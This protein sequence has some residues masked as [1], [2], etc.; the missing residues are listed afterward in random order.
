VRSDGASRYCLDLLAEADE[1]LWLSCHYAGAD[2]ARVAALFAAQVELRRIPGAVSEPPLGEIRLQ[3]WR[4]ALNE[5]VTQAKTRAHPVVEALHATKAVTVATRDLTE[6]LIDA[7][8]RLLYEPS[9]ASI[10]DLARFFAGA[11]APLARLA[12]GETGV[13][14]GEAIEAYALGHALC[15]FAPIIAPA[16]EGDARE[17]GLALMRA[18]R[19]AMKALSAETTGAVAY[20]SL[21]RGYAARGL[22]SWPLA[23][24]ARLFW[25][26]LSGQF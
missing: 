24:R 3:W 17:R 19:A 20:L 8:A 5:V 1:D 11:E 2:L 7:R 18:N 22:K 15:R 13:D 14:A 4:E 21:A 6:R 12:A 23:R 16:L 26:T 9:F 25:T 10:D